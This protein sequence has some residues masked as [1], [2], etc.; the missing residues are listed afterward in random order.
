MQLRQRQVVLDQVFVSAKTAEPIPHAGGL[1]HDA[2][3]QASLDPQVLEIG[4]LRQ[5]GPASAAVDVA[6]VTVVRPDGRFYLDIAPA[7]PLRSLAQTDALEGA[8][9]THGLSRLTIAGEDIMREPS[10]TT[11]RAVWAH[12]RFVV[13]PLMKF[14]ILDALVEDGPATMRQLCSAVPGPQDPFLAVL[15]LACANLLELDIRSQPLG[16]GTVVRSRS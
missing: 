1:F 11:A 2:L 15:S 13:A 14:N 5:A 12:R 4:F 9:S 3:V 8:L 10:F 6:V 16:P 7:R